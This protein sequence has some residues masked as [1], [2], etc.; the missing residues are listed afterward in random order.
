MAVPQFLSSSF[1]YLS[2]TNVVDVQTI[3]NDV[4]A[5]LIANGWSCTAGGSGLTPTTML[6]PARS[7]YARFSITMTRISATILQWQA[8]DHAGNLFSSTSDSARR[9][10][11]S[12]TNTT[13]YYCT[14]E[15]FVHVMNIGGTSTVSTTCIL[16]TAPYPSLLAPIPW[17]FSRYGTGQTFNTGYIWDRATLSYAGY[18]GPVRRHSNQ[19]SDQAA[20]TMTGAWMSNPMDIINYTLTPAVLLGRVPQMIVIDYDVTQE[21]DLVIPIDSGVTGTFIVATGEA[22]GRMAFRKA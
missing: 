8:Y 10:V 5:E 1:R 7:D 13:M 20:K 21:S 2:R 12:A 4:Y 16:D 9:Q 19:N 15:T 11:I 17:Y 22:Y 3:I 6:S 14:G 18:G